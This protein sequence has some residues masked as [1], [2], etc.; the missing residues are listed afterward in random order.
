L[1][2]GFGVIEIILVLLGGIF[3]RMECIVRD[4]PI[5]YEAYGSGLPIIMIH[6]YTP[7]HRLMKGSMEPLFTQRSGWQRI[8]FDLP[9]MGRTPGKEHIKSTDDML[10]VV[11]DFIDAVIPEQPF[12]VAGES[13]GG[14]LSR[15]VL[16]PTVVDDR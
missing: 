5:Y 10:D 1:S 3:R 13:Y 11:V 8:Y 6:G 7:D 15:G 4:V 12:L 16:N 14:Y 9:G 2:G